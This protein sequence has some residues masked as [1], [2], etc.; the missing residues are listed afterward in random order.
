MGTEIIFRGD[1]TLDEIV[2]ELKKILETQSMVVGICE[3]D[4]FFLEIT[5]MKRDE[6]DEH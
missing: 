6:L 5:L 2:K 3:I 1:K 4:E